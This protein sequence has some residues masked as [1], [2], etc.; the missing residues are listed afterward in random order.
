[1]RLKLETSRVQERTQLELPKLD[2]LV[3]ICCS[4][5]PALAFVEGDRLDMAAIRLLA[6]CSVIT[7]TLAQYVAGY[8]VSTGSVRQGG[9]GDLSHPV[10]EA[11]AYV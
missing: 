9:I 8:D 6:V 3:N 5:V 10:L 7:L 1:M 2:F 4:N 11:Q